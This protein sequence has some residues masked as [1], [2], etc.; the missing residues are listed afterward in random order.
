[1]GARAAL[2]LFLRC[3]EV[4]LSRV[5]VVP[6]AAPWP[7]QDVQESLGLCLRTHRL[8]AVLH[9]QRCSAISRDGPAPAV[10]EGIPVWLRSRLE[11]SGVV[12][13]IRND[14]ET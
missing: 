11:C 4:H 3:T 2:L 9:A 5:L 14:A 10:L 13:G 7:C 1:M 8:K 6:A 12:Y